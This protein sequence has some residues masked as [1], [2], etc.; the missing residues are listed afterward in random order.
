MASLEEI[1]QRGGELDE[2]IYSLKLKVSEQ[3]NNLP[4]ETSE[5]LQEKYDL[6]NQEFLHLREKA[7]AFLILRQE[8]QEIKAQIQNQ[9]FDPLLCSLNRFLPPLT[10][11]RY[12]VAVMDGAIPGSIATMEGRELPLELLSTGTAAGLALALRLAISEY[13]LKDMEGTL[14]MDDPLVGLDPARKEQAVIIIREFATLRQIII[15]TCDPD[16]ANLL[17]GTLVE[18]KT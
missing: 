13:L 9:T 15:T 2:V 11:H 8:F 3:K 4:E 14:F 16:T 7:R 17:G 18:L 1:R 6:K 5:E 10:N 12:A